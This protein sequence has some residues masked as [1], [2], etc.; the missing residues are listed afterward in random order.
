MTQKNIFYEN[1]FEFFFLFRKDFLEESIFI[2]RIGF[3]KGFRK[4]SDLFSK[5]ISNKIFFRKKK[6]KK[7]QYN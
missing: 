1:H 2:F 3:L 7:K 6:K 4:Q 5:E